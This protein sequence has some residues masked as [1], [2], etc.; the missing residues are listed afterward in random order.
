MERQLGFLSRIGLFGN[1]SDADWEKFG[2]IDP[3]FGVVSHTEFRGK[4]LSSAART[5]FFSLGEQHV[6]RILDIIRRHFNAAPNGRCLDFGCG[7][8]RLVIPFSR[9]FSHVVGIDISESMLAEAEQNCR[10]LGI[11]NASFSRPMTPA[12]GCF[13]LVHT[14]IVLQHVPAKRALSLAKQ[15]VL[16]TQPGGYCALHFAVG[17]SRSTPRQVATWIRKNIK[18]IHWT[19]NFLS[20]GHLFRPYMQMNALS[21]KDVIVHLQEVGVTQMWLE[22][23]KHGDAYSVMLVF[24]KPH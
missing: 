19:L 10:E 2:Q 14:Y 3:Y 7:V 22:S 11:Q 18:P 20:E 4:K 13:D 8:G 21:L 9:R 6:E 23:E 16:L 24:K 15:L 1:D 17:S 12:L 5:Q